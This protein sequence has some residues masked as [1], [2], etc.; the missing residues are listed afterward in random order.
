VL[1]AH[2]GVLPDNVQVIFENTGK[3]RPETLDF[4]HEVEQRW[5]VP[6]VWL[7][8]R[9]EKPRFRVVDYESA[10][11]NGEPFDELIAWKEFPPNP[12]A[13]MC[14]QHLKVDAMRQYV[15]YHLEW[16]YW[17]S[18]IGIRHDE[19]R[20]W[21]VEAD[22]PKFKREARTIPLRHA[23]VTEEDVF[24]FWSEQPFDLQ[25]KSYEGNC[26]LCY[27]KGRGKRMRIMEENPHLADWWVRKEQETGLNFRS[28]GTYAAMLDY[29][30]RQLRLPLFDDPTDL[31]ECLCHD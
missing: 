3:E 22:D 18:F 9:L 30:K 11:R 24:E 7:E 4:I 16:E 1:K 20:R 28:S 13:R 29:S 15:R 2:G 10:S 6:I 8:W 21:K 14:T 5:S 12:I 23:Q 17:T 31:G 27:L 26:D 25:L 19:P